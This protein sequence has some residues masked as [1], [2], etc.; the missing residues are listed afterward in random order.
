MI[1]FRRR[2]AIA[3]LAFG[4]LTIAGGL[5]YRA[6]EGWSFADGLYMAV[7]TI[8]AVGY[9]EVQPLTQAGRNFTVGLLIAGISW[10]GLWFALITS[11]FVEL[12]LRQVMA[13]RR[14][15]KRLDQL[16]NHIVV[17]GAGRTGLQVL[18]ELEAM[19]VPWVAIEADERRIQTLQERFADGLFVQGDATHDEVLLEAGTDRARGLVACLSADADNLFVCLSARDLKSDLTIVARAYEEETMDKLYRAGAT[20]VVSPNVSGA[21]RMAS[22]LVRPSVVSFLDITTRS[23]DLDLRI[24]QALISNAS[25]LAGRTLAQAEIPAKTGLIVMAVRSTDERD[26][27]RFTFNPSAETRLNVGDELIVLGTPEQIERLRAY[28]TA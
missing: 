2:F 5:G 21:V 28:V 14:L 16:S 13:R 7:I 17:G 8:T 3:L 19:G 11:F 23:S 10:M 6:I 25:R 18:Q 22:M 24:E 20:H 15:M 1:A 4:L 27:G 26:E 12:D 9:G